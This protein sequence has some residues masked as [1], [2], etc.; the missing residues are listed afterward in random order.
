MLLSSLPEVGVRFEDERLSG[1]PGRP[2]SLL[3]PPTGCRFRTRCPFA[4]DK[5]AEE[6]PFEAVEPAHAAACWKAAA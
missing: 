6:P 1:I 3:D 4:F 2:P 5:C